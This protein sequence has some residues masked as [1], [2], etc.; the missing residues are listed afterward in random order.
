MLAASPSG[1][2]HGGRVLVGVDEEQ[3]GGPLLV[4]QCRESAEQDSAVRAV[5]QREA[6][7]A[8]RAEDTAVDA[9]DR[10]QQRSLVRESANTS[11]GSGQV[12]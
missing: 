12:Q 10:G 1:E 8:E 4:A 11:A 9:V 2:L 5:E 3:T 6:L 7:L